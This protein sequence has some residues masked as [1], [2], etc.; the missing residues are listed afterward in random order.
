VVKIRWPSP[1]PEPERS[2]D[3]GT[4]TCWNIEALT[5]PAGWEVEYESEPP[6]PSTGSIFG[7]NALGFVR[8]T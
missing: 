1:E 8:W 2:Q 5:R 4:V 7:P 6:R 3:E